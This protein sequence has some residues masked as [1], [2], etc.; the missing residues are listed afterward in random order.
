MTT[1]EGAV[2]GREVLAF[3]LYGTPVDPIAI[4]AELGP[5]LG[6]AD[7]CAAAGLW[8]AQAAGVLL[9]AHRDGPLR[10]LRVGDGPRA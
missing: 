10:G 6:D 9:Q 1:R 4:A 3:D 8:R 7:G 2:N 5:L